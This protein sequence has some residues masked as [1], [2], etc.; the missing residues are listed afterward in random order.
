MTIMRALRA[1]FYVCFRVDT[2]NSMTDILCVNDG[3]AGDE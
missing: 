3:F 1:L 2:T